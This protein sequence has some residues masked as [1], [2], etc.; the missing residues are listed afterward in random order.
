[1]CVWGEG[2]G[3]GGQ[4]V[5]YSF[6]FK[7]PANHCEAVQDD[8]VHVHTYVATTYIHMCM[9]DVSI[10]WGLQM[11]VCYTFTFCCQEFIINSLQDILHNDH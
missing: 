7:E 8:Y 11:K 9:Y 4:L 3:E 5:R 2:E 10:Y 6:T 1:M